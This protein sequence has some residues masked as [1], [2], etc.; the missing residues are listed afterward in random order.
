MSRKFRSIQELWERTALEWATLLFLLE[1][2]GSREGAILYIEKHYPYRKPR[3]HDMPTECFSA[4][5]LWE[6]YDKLLDEFPIGSRPFDE[7]GDR[8][9]RAHPAELRVIR[10]L[11]KMYSGVEDPKDKNL[12]AW[13]KANYGVD[14]LRFVGP[15]VVAPYLIMAALCELWCMKEEFK[16]APRPKRGA[17]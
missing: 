11:W 1:L 9:G 10:W 2:C 5:E 15:S 6:L 17:K 12:S 13:L 4:Q 7:L 16:T 3:I 8:R 14:S